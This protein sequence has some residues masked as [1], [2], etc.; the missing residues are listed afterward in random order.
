M[1][2]IAY[3]SDC[4]CIN[5]GVNSALLD[6][7]CKS[8]KN[9]KRTG[10]TGVLYLNKNTFL[11]IIEGAR[12]TLESL[13]ITL[14]ADTRHKNIVRI[15]DEEVFDRPAGI[16]RMDSF[17]VHSLSLSDGEYIDLKNL[18]KAGVLKLYQKCI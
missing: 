6:I 15:I 18:T 10:I 7:T 1:H 8:R 17:S 3:T 11:H 2:V 13:M 9:N 4:Q 16:Q 5:N 12:D 14:R